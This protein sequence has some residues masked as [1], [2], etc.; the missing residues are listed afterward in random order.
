M[1]RRAG[2]LQKLYNNKRPIIFIQFSA[3][4]DLLPKAGPS[5]LYSLLKM[6]W[7]MSD[8][9]EVIFGMLWTFGSNKNLPKP[10]N[11]SLITKCA[12]TQL[13]M[14]IDESRVVLYIIISLL[15]KPAHP[16]LNSNMTAILVQSVTKWCFQRTL[17]NRG[18]GNCP[19]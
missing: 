18:P 10:T 19:A 17:W 12:R 2:V 14:C 5:E 16:A 3:P 1:R 13:H 7:F 6:V 11:K 15:F 9:D 8:Y 4:A